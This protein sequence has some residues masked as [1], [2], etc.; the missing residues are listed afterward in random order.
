MVIVETGQTK[1]TNCI[2][3]KCKL[4]LQGNAYTIG[5]IINL[6]TKGRP[7]RVAEFDET[8]SFF[9]KKEKNS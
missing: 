2:V 3:D 6:F 8:G 7:L 1:L 4:L 5:Q 9:P